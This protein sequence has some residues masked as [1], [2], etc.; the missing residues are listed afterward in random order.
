MELAALPED[1]PHRLVAD[2]E[3]R[4]EGA[5]ASGEG[6]GP[7]GSQL[8][9]AKALGALARIRSATGRPDGAPDG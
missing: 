3:V 7:D 1:R 8:F 9:L 5:Q 2:A 6:Q 4:G